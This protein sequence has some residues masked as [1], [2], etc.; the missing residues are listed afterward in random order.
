MAMCFR[1]NIMNMIKKI[2]G[3]MLIASSITAFGMDDG[4]TAT[5]TTA[6]QTPPTKWDT[7]LRNAAEGGDIS[8]AKEAL[9]Y[10]ANPKRIWYSIDDEP[11]TPTPTNP[12]NDDET[13]ILEIAMSESPPIAKLLIQKIQP[14]ANLKLSYGAELNDLGMIKA[15]L[16]NGADINNTK[17]LGL[18]PLHL[19]YEKDIV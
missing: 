12:E 1:G 16:K 10:G 7:L 11:F 4:P 13:T 14:P 8:L 17:Y 2:L 3:L 5:S 15:A 6:V 18:T 19:A 9:K